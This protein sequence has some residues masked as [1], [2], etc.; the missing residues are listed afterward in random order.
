MSFVRF[1]GGGDN[2]YVHKYVSLEDTLTIKILPCNQYH[3]VYFGWNSTDSNISCWAKRA[4]FLK[5]EWCWIGTVEVLYSSSTAL[6][7]FQTFCVLC[8]KSC[9]FAGVSTHCPYGSCTQ[10]SLVFVSI[11]H[12]A[13]KEQLTWTM[14][15][16]YGKHLTSP[17]ITQV[18]VRLC[19]QILLS[20]PHM[21][22]YKMN[23]CLWSNNDVI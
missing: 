18:C 5:L 8:N 17:L 15:L 23:S 4:M 9:C 14:Y 13:A 19:C 1:L 3:S 16:T 12:Q 21:N 22:G 2:I 20:I 10:C 7:S 11:V 6:A